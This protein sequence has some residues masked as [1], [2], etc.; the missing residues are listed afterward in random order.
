MKTNLLLKLENMLQEF[1]DSDEVSEEYYFI[2]SEKELLA[3][4]VAQEMDV[5]DATYGLAVE[6][7]ENYAKEN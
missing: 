6:E 2:P 3:S 7:T 4:L 5:I 1:L